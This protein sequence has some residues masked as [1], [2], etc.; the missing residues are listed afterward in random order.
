MEITELTPNLRVLS[1]GAWYLYLWQDGESRT[2]IDTG[3]PGNGA[4]IAAAF[5]GLDRIVLT[6]FHADHAGSA[7]ELREWSG[8]PVVAGAADAAII[9]GATPPPRRCWRTGSVPSWNASPPASRRSRPLR[10]SIRR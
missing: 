10:R 7:A 1:I 9:R 5:R 8:A 3:A 4:A 6:H 2:L